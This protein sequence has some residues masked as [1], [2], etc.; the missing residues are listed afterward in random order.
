MSVS[1]ELLE[2]MDERERAD[3][4]RRLIALHT[5]PPPA[6]RRWSLPPAA[7]RFRHRFLVVVTAACVVLIPWIVLLGFTL[8]NRHVATNWTLTWIGFDVGLLGA[9]GVT[10]WLTYKRRQAM[11][12]AAFITGT[13]LVCD[14]WFDITTASGGKDLWLGVASALIGELPLA[15]LL[16]GSAWYLLRLTVQ[17]ART[18]IG[19]RESRTRLSQLPLFGVPT[20]TSD[21]S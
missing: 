21:A 9:L 18:L 8:P 5:P 7:A 15:V 1:D 3:L 14:A 20:S 4:L 17:R 10:A 11:I 2:E 12:I 13:L 6:R 19:A 16:F